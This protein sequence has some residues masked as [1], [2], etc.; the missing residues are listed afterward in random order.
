MSYE[1]LDVGCGTR[2][3]GDVNIDLYS[4]N[5]QQCGTLWDPKKV[6]TFII[7][8]AEVL[9]FQNKVFKKIYAIHVIEHLKNPFQALNEWKRV[10]K[11]IIIQTPSAYDPDR[12]KTHIYTWNK[13]TLEN[14]LE[15]VFKNV[16]VSY[17]SARLQLYGRL[18]RYIPLLQFIINRFPKEIKAICWD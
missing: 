7:A 17:T 15:L 8:D 3:K 9:P 5:L 16:E 12:T 4:K 11:V 6:K 13:F 1:T 10:G 2:P 18:H 14:L